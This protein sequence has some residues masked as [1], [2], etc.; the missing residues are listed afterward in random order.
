MDETLIGFIVNNPR[1]LRTMPG[2]YPKR[3]CHLKRRSPIS[4]P[5]LAREVSSSGRRRRMHRLFR[6]QVCYRQTKSTTGWPNNGGVV[7]RGP[8][9]PRA[10][11][12]PTWQGECEGE[13]GPALH[14]MHPTRLWT[15][16]FACC[17][18]NRTQVIFRPPDNLVFV[19]CIHKFLSLISPSSLVLHPCV[20]PASQIFAIQ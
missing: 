8:S 20:L 13:R 10:T 15:Q 19:G 7:R 12:T 11:T 17:D 1:V 16:D 2:C 6:K 5:R 3:G 4:L 14:C 9:L 18:Y